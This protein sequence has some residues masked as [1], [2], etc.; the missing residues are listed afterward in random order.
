MSIAYRLCR[1]HMRAPVV[2]TICSEKLYYDFVA[3]INEKWISFISDLIANA[4]YKFDLDEMGRVLFQP[5]QYIFS[6]QPVWTYNDGNIS[7]L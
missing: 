1:E 7:I 2:E 4:K 6:L 5:K 3:D